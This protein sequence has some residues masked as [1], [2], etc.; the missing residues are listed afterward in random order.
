MKNPESNIVVKTEHNVNLHSWTLVPFL[1]GPAKKHLVYVH[2]MKVQLLTHAKCDH[3]L[4]ALV[5]ETLFR[6]C[7]SG[8]RDTYK[9]HGETVDRELS[10]A[11]HV[12]WS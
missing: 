9:F 8:L 3:G 7:F 1:K 2:I 10:H 4:N 12:Q 5:T 6:I 11:L